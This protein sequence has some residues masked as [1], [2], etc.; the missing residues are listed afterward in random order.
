MRN[1][2]K[3]GSAISLTLN[4]RTLDTTLPGLGQSKKILFRNWNVG[5]VLMLNQI[6]LI[7]LFS[8]DILPNTPNMTVHL[9]IHILLSL[10]LY[11]K[12]KDIC[13]LL[14]MCIRLVILKSKSFLNVAYRYFQCRMMLLM[15]IN[16][17]FSSKLIPRV[18]VFSL[19]VLLKV[20]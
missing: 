5:L 13:H 20:E 19:V 16:K 4:P 17:N 7:G 8:D 11:Q 15:R 10:L 3:G 6:C 12:H 1:I 18:S 14:S 2:G 9:L